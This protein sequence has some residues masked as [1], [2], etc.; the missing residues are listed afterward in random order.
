MVSFLALGL[1]LAGTGN[2]TFGDSFAVVSYCL[3]S[4]A[5]I[6]AVMAISQY[7]GIQDLGPG[8]PIRQEA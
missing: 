4:V 2:L 7:L 6:F 3:A 5:I 8:N 1:A